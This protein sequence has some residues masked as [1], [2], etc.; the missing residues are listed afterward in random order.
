MSLLKKGIS[1]LII[2]T[3]MMGVTGCMNTS[4]NEYSKKIEDGLASKYKEKF[5]VKGLGG[6]WGTHDDS[7]MKAD[8]YNDTKP[9]VTFRVEIGK[10][11]FAIKDSYMD[12]IMGDKYSESMSEI[13]KEKNV[14]NKFFSVFQMTDEYSSETDKTESV[15][16]YV[17]KSPQIMSTSFV[18]L[19]EENSKDDISESTLNEIASSFSKDISNVTVIFYSVKSDFNKIDEL[20][21]SHYSD[22][23]DFFKTYKNVEKKAIYSV[24]DGKTTITK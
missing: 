24:E 20:Y 1:G 19:N 13:I 9:T 16:D 4:K 23:Y 21:Y 3:M 5:T 11:D 14:E 6:S 12:V 8:C 7:T 17:S 22:T 10:K 15:S 2:L 18:F